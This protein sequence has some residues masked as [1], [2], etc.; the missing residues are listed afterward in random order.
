[1]TDAAYSN[2]SRL[3]KHYSVNAGE[4]KGYGVSWKGV[5]DS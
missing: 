1:M 4:A 2:A 3:I 5:L